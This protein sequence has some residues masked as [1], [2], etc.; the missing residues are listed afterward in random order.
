MLFEDDTV[1]LFGNSSLDKTLRAALGGG[2]CN[3]G[4]QIGGC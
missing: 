2:G 1:L 4:K 3:C